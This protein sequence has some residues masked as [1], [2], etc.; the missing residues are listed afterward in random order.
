MGRLNRIGKR[1][2]EADEQA[3]RRC[4]ENHL[5]P[6]HLAETHL[7]GS[8]QVRDPDT[9][10]QNAERAL[11]VALDDVVI[12]TVKQGDH[13]VICEGTLNLGSK[14]MYEMTE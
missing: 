14:S 12:D 6:P 13:R 5:I 10:P 8:E 7:S 11:G 9:V 3:Q 4:P 2:R 1:V